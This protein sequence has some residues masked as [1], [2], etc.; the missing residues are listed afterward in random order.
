MYWATTTFRVTASTPELRAVLSAWRDHIAATHPQVKEVRCYRFNGG[1]SYVWQEGFEDF[2][3][4]QELID[5]EDA[6]CKAVM[7]PVFGYAVPG[8][9][10]G[11]IWADGL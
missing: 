11:R 10:E 6:S 8:S 4:Y 7:G 9:R 2:H 1:T 5:A 3:A